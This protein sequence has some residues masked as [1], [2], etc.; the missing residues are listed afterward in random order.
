MPGAH[1]LVYLL[2]HLSQTYTTSRFWFLKKRPF[3]IPSDQ[4]VKM[5]ERTVVK[6]QKSTCANG[7]YVSYSYQHSDH[8]T[9]GGTFN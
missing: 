6:L 3:S 8:T 9:V 5:V 4:L 1:N 7:H 2:F